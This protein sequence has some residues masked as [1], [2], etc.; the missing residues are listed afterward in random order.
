MSI[1]IV[2]WYTKDVPFGEDIFQDEYLIYELAI[3]YMAKS[4]KKYW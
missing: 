3:H 1:K 2:S 4:N